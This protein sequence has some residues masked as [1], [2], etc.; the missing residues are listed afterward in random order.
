M[1][2]IR[3]WNDSDHYLKLSYRYYLGLSVAK[4]TQINAFTNAQLQRDFPLEQSTMAVEGLLQLPTCEIGKCRACSENK[5]CI[6]N[7]ILAYT[8]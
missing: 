2:L 3:N 7:T 5:N 1:D 8:E 6:R 4:L